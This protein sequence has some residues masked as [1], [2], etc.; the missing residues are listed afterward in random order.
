MLKGGNCW[1][2]SQ[3]ANARILIFPGW[4][5]RKQDDWNGRSS[6]VGGCIRDSHCL[7]A[8]QRVNHAPRKLCQDETDRVQIT[9]FQM[10]KLCGKIHNYLCLR[11]SRKSSC[12]R[13]AIESR[14]RANHDSWKTSNCYPMIEKLLERVSGINICFHSGSI[15]WSNINKEAS[16]TSPVGRELSIVC[17]FEYPKIPTCHTWKSGISQ[18]ISE[19]ENH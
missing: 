19:G 9:S 12:P 10:V 2:G 1:S 18:I 6:A 17:R 7:S 15:Y 4:S 13:R 16:R 14:I 5:W 11:A 3:N 8:G